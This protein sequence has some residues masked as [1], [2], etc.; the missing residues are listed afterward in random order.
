[1][2][3]TLVG[4]YHNLFVKQTR[5]L[6]PLRLT[7]PAT[8]DMIDNPRHIH[9]EDLL[10]DIDAY[11]AGRDEAG[12]RLARVLDAPVR[13]EA[14]RFL[15]SEHADVDDVVQDTMLSLLKYL[16]RCDAPVAN[17]VKLAATIARNRCRDLVRW[18]STKVHVDITPMDE[19]L[20]DE[21]RSPLDDLEKSD[22][23]ELLGRALAGISVK[24]RRLLVAVFYEKQSIESI[25]QRAGLGTVQAVYYRRTECLRQAR[26]ELEKMLA[27]RPPRPNGGSR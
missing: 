15:G 27:V 10:T 23:L 26:R 14:S 24:C 1:M 13:L 6:R 18:R 16:R 4:N 2:D 21:S 9:P 7:A 11:R 8:G 17:L 12:E 20:A 5:F 19:W 22:R 25:R 3:A